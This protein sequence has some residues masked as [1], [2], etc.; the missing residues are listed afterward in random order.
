MYKKCVLT[1]I[2]VQL[3]LLFIITP[4]A[5]EAEVPVANGEVNNESEN[6][7]QLDGYSPDNDH[8]FPISPNNESVFTKR[9]K[10][11]FTN[12][13]GATEFFIQ[14]WEQDPPYGEVYTL[15]GPGVCNDFYCYL[16]PTQALKRRTIDYSGGYVWR[17]QA[18]VGGVWYAYFEQAY[19]S[20][21]SKGFNDSFSTES[22]KWHAW[23]GDWTWNSIKGRMET[24]GKFGEYSSLYHQEAFIN[25]EYTVRLKRKIDD[26]HMSSIV[27]MGDPGPYM[28]KGHWYNGIYFSY[29][30]T[31]QW[32]L[33]EVVEGGLPSSVGWHSDDAIN[34]FGW[35][36]LKVRVNRP[37]VDM[38]IN[39]KYLGWYKTTT[40]DGEFVGIDMF[41]S[42]LSGDTFLV[43]WATMVPIHF[44]TFSEH[45]PAMRLTLNP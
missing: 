6:L 36:V 17:V 27:F 18:L 8:A 23:N 28:P 26:S 40:L 39:D 1:A 5:A 43:D 15:Q 44:S 22:L 10:F 35:N 25:Y 11:Y 33:W 31:G 13:Y 41:S 7:F 4:V 14:V 9:P 45:D 19:F 3:L 29:V 24:A 20:V 42:G 12:P 37:Y 34:K 30:N 21:L 38:W 16:Q 32:S 2:A